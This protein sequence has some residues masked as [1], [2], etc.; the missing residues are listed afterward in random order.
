[1]RLGVFILLIL[2]VGCSRENFRIRADKD[3]EAVLSQK[4]IVP[5]WK[6]ENWHVYPDTRARFAD[7]SHPDYPPYP[8]DDYATWLTAP[9]PQRPGKGGAGRFEGAGYIKLIQQ[10]DAIN[11][12]EDAQREAEQADLKEDDNPSA[13][14]DLPAD[15]GVPGETVVGGTAASFARV[16][17][18]E[19]NAYKL[20]LEQAIEL[21]LFNSREFQ[22][23]RE[24]LYLAALPVTLERY[25]FA[26]QAFATEQLIRESGGRDFPGGGG[27]RWRVNTDI[28][29]NRVFATGA[30]LMVR[31]ANQ[32]V[33]DLS[34]PSPQTSLS[35]LSLTF[36]QPLLR[37]GGYAVTLEA[38]TQV[39][40]TLI[41]A[42]RSYA[43]FRKTFYVA[44]AG[45]GNYTN[46]PYG[47]Q[48]L[49]TNLGRGVGA[50][51]TAVAVGYLPTVLQAA[52]LAN[53]RK[54]VEALEQ[55]LFL[56]ENLKEGGGV[57]EL[58]VVRVE[59]NLIRS[60][61]DV[62]QST[63][64]YLDSIDNFKL[65]L[66]VPATLPIELDD[67]PLLPVRRHLQR[68]DRL[69]GQLRQLEN[70]AGEFTPDQPVS[71]YRQ[72]WEKLLTESSLV[73]GTPF[74]NNYKEVAA[75]LR[76]LTNQELEERLTVLNAERRQLLDQRAERQIKGLAET[77]EEA[78][79]I[80][81]LEAEYDRIG[82]EQA[83][84]RYEEANWLALPIDRQ[85]DARAV[86]F[87]AALDAGLLVAIQPRN[88]RLDAIRMEWPELP[89]II[90]EGGDLLTRPLDEAYATVARTALTN[91]YDLMNAR[92]QVVDSWR[93]ITVNA[94]A[95]QGVFDVRYDLD[96]NTPRN[97]TSFLG[98][99][100]T[101]TRHRVTLQ[102]EPPFVRRAE[103]N[104]YRASLIGYQRSRRNLMSF[105]DNIITDSRSDLRNLR[106]LAESYYLQQRVVELAYAQVDNARSTF[107]APPDPLSGR[108]A[109]GEAAALTQQ[110]LEAQNS[111]LQ[112]QNSLFSNWVTYQT[113]RM[114]LY[115]D[116]EML[117]LDAR[118]LW[119]DEYNPYAGPDANRPFGPT[120]TDIPDFVEGVERPGTPPDGA[121]APQPPGQEIAR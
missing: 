27:E 94:N 9:N 111:L 118:G 103:R 49:S 100:G 106:Q 43:R 14:P 54:N 50:N 21:A 15:T 79:A 73:K 4:N 95:L 29:L 107:L 52:I 3:V 47:L 26:A 39:E 61:N 41:Y 7:P 98:F 87:R 76:K 45:N 22:F 86:A 51:L 74:A 121:D 59:Q 109:A 75:E 116:L 117:P 2:A 112:A 40:R 13:L 77:E 56:F 6:I 57:S 96:T 19:E 71:E 104:L 60:R 55:F 65:Q 30:E 48:G 18:L 101:R 44:L 34:G 31:L 69:Y 92:A 93:S 68:F 5:D 78:A 64:Q 108:G 17:D 23:R 12:A 85:D 80:A 25:G 83:L 70:E 35:N 90:V 32:V 38:L 24:D 89:K 99:G 110:L 102:L 1:M 88:E 10:W 82:F 72:R 67:G 11:R 28:G 46:N 115:L 37:G 66:G 36:I 20:R 58:Q 16:F 62:L 53:Q 97:E 8:P 42:I 113:L 63:R 81:A 120:A 91:R 105:E 33:V 84:R 114:N 119:N